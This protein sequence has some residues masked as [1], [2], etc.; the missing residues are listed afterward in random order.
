MA[1]NYSPKIVTNGLVTCLDAGN[2]KSYVGTGTTWRNLIVGPY[3]ATL[4]NGPTFNTDFGGSIVFDASNDQ[5]DTN[6]P[7]DLTNITGTFSYECWALP[8][9]TTSLPGQ[10]GSGITTTSGNRWIIYSD[11]RG[12]ARGV[13]MCVGTNGVSV[14]EH[15]ANNIYAP[16]THAYTFSSTLFTNVTVVVSSGSPNLYINGIF[17]KTGVTSGSTVYPSFSIIGSGAY[18]L[19]GGRMA[20]IKLYNYALTASQVNSNFNN[21]KARFGVS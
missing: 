10:S 15:G 17:Q 4:T 9:L 13:G 21:L 16:L 6:Y 1:V 3:V 11:N 19:Y 12:S 20:I 5:V 14:I 18:G 8:T 7:T 2:R